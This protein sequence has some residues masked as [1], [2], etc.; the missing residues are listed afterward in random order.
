M[1]AKVLL[2]RRDRG[3]DGFSRRQVLHPERVDLN[4]TISGLMQM[5]RR[6]V[7][8]DVHFDLSLAP[9]LDGIEADKGQIE[10]VV[11]N[12]IINASDAMPEGGRI[13]LETANVFLPR[14]WGGEP[15][16]AWQPY[17]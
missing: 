2:R 4:E 1:R 3:A 8:E 9:D 11:V 14:G 10:Q 6:L 5:A 13:T 15:A 16:W 12:L 7:R 17:M